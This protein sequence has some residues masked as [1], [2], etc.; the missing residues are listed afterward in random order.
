MSVKIKGT[1]KK[2]EGINNGLNSIESSLRKEP[3]TERFV[4]GVI[5]TARDGNDYEKG[6]KNTVIKFVNI[7][8]L[9]GEAAIDAAKLFKLAYNARTGK[10]EPQGQLPFGEAAEQD[11]TAEPWPGDPEFKQP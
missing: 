11:P 5:Q 1:F 3:L 10:A 4:I 6:E 2:N 9:E 8:P 7:E